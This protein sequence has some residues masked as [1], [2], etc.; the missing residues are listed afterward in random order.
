MYQRPYLS[1]CSG[2]SCLVWTPDR[3]IPQGGTDAKYA[4]LVPIAEFEGGRIQLAFDHNEILTDA[5]ERARAKIEYTTVATEFCKPEFTLSELRA[6]Y[7]MVWDTKPPLD[8]GNFQRKVTHA[9]DRDDRDYVISIGKNSEPGERGGRPAALYRAG[10]A[11]KIEP[12]I[13]RP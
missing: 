10:P 2:V 5:I 6:V 12:P 1:N 7:D 9:T 13:I 8:A 11:D 4:E 3:C